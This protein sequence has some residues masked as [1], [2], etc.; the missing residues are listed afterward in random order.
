MGRQRKHCSGAGAAIPLVGSS[1]QS[2]AF[3]R[4]GR[5]DLDAG[6]NSKGALTVRLPPHIRKDFDS[7][8]TL[9]LTILLRLFYGE[10]L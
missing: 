5:R 7:F 10:P 6:S 8:V 2:R 3:V 4:V 9:Q 1:R